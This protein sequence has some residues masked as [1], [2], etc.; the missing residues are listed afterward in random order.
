M[1]FWKASRYLPASCHRP[2][3][4]PHPGANEEAN[5]SQRA[6]VPSKCSSKSCQRSSGASFRLW[7]YRL[8]VVISLRLAVV[9]PKELGE[10]RLAGRG[11]RVALRG[12]QVSTLNY[13]EAEQP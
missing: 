13:T 10:T 9:S 6:A 5:A 4:R 11:L 12:A 7:A 8:G 2:A 3:K 1:C